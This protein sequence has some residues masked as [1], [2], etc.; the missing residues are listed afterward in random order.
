MTFPFNQ[1]FRG[2]AVKFFQRAK[3]LVY[4]VSIFQIDAKMCNFDAWHWALHSEWLAK[5]LWVH[6]YFFRHKPPV[7]KFLL[8]NVLYRYENMLHYNSKFIFRKRFKR[9]VHNYLN[10]WLV[11]LR[12]AF[13][14]HINFKLA[15]KHLVSFLNILM[16]Y[17]TGLLQSLNLLLAFF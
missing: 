2:S 1:N 11:Q 16:S 4:I 5:I 12:Q 9:V 8:L 6:K 15:L 3:I 14:Q 10:H 17:W 13:H 7:N